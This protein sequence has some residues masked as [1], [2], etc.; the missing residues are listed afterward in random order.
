[1][2]GRVFVEIKTSV[3]E[4]PSVSIIRVGIDISPDDETKIPE[5]LV[6]NSTL[7]PPVSQED[8]ILLLALK[9]SNLVKF[10]SVYCRF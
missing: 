3:S 5:A 2:I 10:P 1:M 9:F 6:F 8:F 4:A 7:T